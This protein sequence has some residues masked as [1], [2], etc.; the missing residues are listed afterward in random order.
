MIALQPMHVFVSCVDLVIDADLLA[1][2]G[3]QQLTA[4]CHL[5]MFNAQE[6][7]QATQQRKP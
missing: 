5:P 2:H 6:L 3:R 7:A 1:A 4:P